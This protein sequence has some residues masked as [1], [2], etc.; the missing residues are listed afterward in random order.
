MNTMSGAE[1]ARLLDRLFA[2]GRLTDDDHDALGQFESGPEPLAGH[3]V[4]VDDECAG[5]AAS[6][7]FGSQGSIVVGS[8][9]PREPDSEEARERMDD[10]EIALDEPTDGTAESATTGPDR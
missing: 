7:S 4:V 9:D 10:H 2:G 5:S 1:L 3:R 6:D 8:I